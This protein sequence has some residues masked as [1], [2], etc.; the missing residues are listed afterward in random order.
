MGADNATM[1]RGRRIVYRGA[2]RERTLDR[3]V[4]RFCTIAAAAGVLACCL[5]GSPC[6][7]RANATA[8]RAAA[9][10][11]ATRPGPIPIIIDTDIGEDIDDLLTL[12]FAANSPEFEI[13]AVTTVDG[14]T[15]GRGRIARRVLSLYGQGHVPVSAGYTRSMPSANE[16]VRPGLAVRYGAVAPDEEGLPP[17]CPVPADDLIARIAADRPGQVYLLTIGSMTNA[18]QALLRH[19]AVARDLRGIITNG[20]NFGPGRQTR[21]GWNL[22]YDPVAAATAARSQAR[23]VLL[24]E[25]MR[26]LGGMTREDVERVERRGLATTEILMLGIR[27]W[28]RNKRECTP[29]SVP[30]L[31]DL[32][33]LAYLLGIVETEPGRA[34]L[35]VGPRDR[36]AELRVELDAAGPHLLGWRA[37]RDRGRE[38][39]D[40]FMERLLAEPRARARAPG[41]GQ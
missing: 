41:Q 6:P 22:R 19:P 32:R 26:N 24:P 27:E 11:P 37:R 10:A 16:P 25:G 40:L 15:A 23:W 7:A 39:H 30:H 5:P 4:R 1:A 31:S 8:S 13:L 14:D 29:E 2:M 36:T 12:A 17:A 9:S 33:V 35:V 38:L 21:I 34:W 3:S 18:G 20:G 28:R